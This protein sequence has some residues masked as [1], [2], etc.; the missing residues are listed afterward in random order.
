MYR[1]FEDRKLSEEH[2]AEVEKQIDVEMNQ[3]QHLLA[4]MAP[5]EREEFLAQQ[6]MFTEVT[7]EMENIEQQIQECEKQEAR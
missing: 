4:G 6:K 1:I 7:E 5:R 2:L 3:T